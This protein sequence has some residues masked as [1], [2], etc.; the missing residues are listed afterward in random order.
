[1]LSECYSTFT[2]FDILSIKQQNSF[3]CL[4]TLF[5]AFQR[6]QFDPVL[7]LML[8]GII[9]YVNENDKLKYFDRQMNVLIH[10]CW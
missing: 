3:A 9:E 1:M 7:H 2:A 4:V 6:Y 8:M 10:I 5:A